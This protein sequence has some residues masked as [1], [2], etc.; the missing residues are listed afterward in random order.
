[1]THDTTR[2]FIYAR[3]STDDLSRQVRSI[4]DQIAEL[5]T[6]ADREQLCV[7]EVLTE[8]Q[9]AKV[10]GRPVFNRM[11]ERIEAGEASGVLAW[12][13]DRLARNS[14]DAGRIIHFVDR[15]LI[16]ALRFPIFPFDPTAAGKFML[17][18]IFGQSKY[19]VDNLSENIRRGQRQKLLNGLWPQ[20][21]P[22]GYLNDRRTKNITLDPQRAPIL[23]KIFTLFATGKYTY[24][25]ITEIGTELGMTSRGGTLLSRAQYHRILK[26]PI[27]F[28]VIRWSGEIYDGSHEPLVSKDI[29]DRVQEVI[30]GRR[31]A[32]DKVLKPY[33]YRRLFR[34]AECGG[35]ITTETQK[36][37]NYLRCTKK[38]GPCSQR[39]VREDEVSRQVAVALERIMLDHTDIDSL[40]ER[41]TAEV[42][43]DN[44]RS[45]SDRVAA[46]ENVVQVDQKIDRLTTAYAEN[47]LTLDEYRRAKAVAIAEKTVAKE[48][49]ANLSA[50]T[51]YWLE[52]TQRFVNSLREATLTTKGTETAKKT[53]LF[54]KTGSN[55]KIQDR[56]IHL[57][58]RGPWKSIEKHGHLAHHEIAARESRA[59]S[60]GKSS[61]V[62]SVA[63]EMRF[64]LMRPLRAYRFS[65]PAHSTAL[66]LLRLTHAVYSR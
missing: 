8:K 57:D 16:N 43:D 23:R 3:K 38:K 22:L 34:C 26:N 17:A 6:L 10:P 54:K 30:R 60:H 2:F 65:R 56:K 19:Y 32:K 61:H 48:R 9:S 33:Q 28:G 7:L 66:P 1:M 39:F 58:F 14:V 24:D 4:D 45:E 53:E 37:N 35:F 62:V 31:K 40:E 36:G 47:L 59:A 27:Y 12:H 20:W 15:K 51:S 50:N 63:E 42:A 5:K 46:E 29:F 41:L 55:L 18:I 52:P 11:L 25:A 64:E 49:M 44:K 21:A 13:P